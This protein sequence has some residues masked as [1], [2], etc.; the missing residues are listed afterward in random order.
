MSCD[1]VAV[2][3]VFVR[4]PL[5]DRNV[6]G[7]LWNEVDEQSLPPELRQRLERNGFRVGLIGSDVPEV[8]AKLLELS[9]KPPRRDFQRTVAAD[10]EANNHPAQRHLQMR[11]GRRNEIIAS[12]VYESL[13]VLVSEAGDLRGQTYSQAQGILATRAFPRPT[14]ACGWNWCPSC[15]TI[16]RGPVSLATR[17]LCDWTPPGPSRCSTN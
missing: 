7:K 13:P 3:I 6:N 1:S 14:A 10:M 16:S 8:L 15:T 9:D 5:G 12:G 2:D 4:C 17:R 11:A